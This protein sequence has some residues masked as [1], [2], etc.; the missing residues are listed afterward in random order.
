MLNLEYMTQEEKKE[1][2]KRYQAAYRAKN[3]EKQAEYAKKYRDQNTEKVA[4]YNKQYLQDH[5]EQYAEYARRRDPEA[6]AAYMKQYYAANKEKLKDYGREWYRKF[7]KE[8]QPTIEALAGRPRPDACEVCG[9]TN[10]AGN[11]RLGV[12][13]VFD[14]DHQTGKFRGWLCDAC[15][16]ALGLLK[17]NPD[18]LRKLADYLT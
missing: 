13:T 8:K 16:T 3:R 7:A 15:N 18:T 17:D 4:L 14:H 12:K 5:K 10:Y 1:A 9:G 6:K 2:Q 11:G